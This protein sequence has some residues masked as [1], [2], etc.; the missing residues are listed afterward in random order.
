MTSK[1]LPKLEDNCKTQHKL[2][3]YSDDKG[4]EFTIE[5]CSMLIMKRGKR[6]MMEG[7]E[8]PNQEKI[9]MLGVMEIY[10]YLEILKADTIKQSE[11]KE[12]IWKKILQENEKT[13]RHQ[14]P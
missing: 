3:R 1:C 9:R 13:T 2:W 7:I 4:M 12:K 5:K 10:K 8:L 11:M 14:T 6:Q